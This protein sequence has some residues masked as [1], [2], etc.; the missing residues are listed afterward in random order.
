M[1]TAIAADLAK[2]IE[3]KKKLLHHGIDGRAGLNEDDDLARLFDGGDEVFEGFAA[4]EAAW[5]VLAGDEF[6][7][8]VGGAV[9]DG[10]FVAV[11][12]DVEGEIF[13]HNCETDEVSAG[14]ST[15]RIVLAQCRL[16]SATAAIRT[17]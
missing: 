1:S 16:V 10:D 9:V 15:L 11:V 2:I 13:A 5:G 8:D 4:D 12:S 14:F 7:H 3:L 6:F 17:V